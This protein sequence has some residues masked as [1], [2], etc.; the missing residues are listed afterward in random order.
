MRMLRASGEPWGYPASAALILAL[1]AC[2]TAFSTAAA[3]V[4]VTTQLNDI[5]RT[6]QNTQETALTPANVNPAQF[7]KLFSRSVAGAID[8][9]PLY[10]SSIT[11]NGAVHNVVYVVT[12]PNHVYAFDANSNYGAN[13]SPLWYASMLTAA[14]GAA[15]GAQIYGDLGSTS[16]PVIDPVSGTMYLVSTTLESGA[17]VYRLH[18]LDVTSG[19]EK[20]GGPTVIEASVPGAAAD[21]VDG[22]VSLIPQ[23]HNQRPGLLLLS[24]RPPSGMGGSSPTARRL[25]PRRACSA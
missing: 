13:S 25:W 8:A 9:Q 4:N 19:A 17:P 3:Q 14:H 18:A 23:D 21:G 10:L 20:F 1:L 24:R 16:T 5:G 12:Q 15:P 7:G 11:I 6:G 2:V 22:I